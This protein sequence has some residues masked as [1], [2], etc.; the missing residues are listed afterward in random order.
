MLPHE[1]ML[2]GKLGGQPSIA[3][4]SALNAWYLSDG[5]PEL[6]GLLDSGCYSIDVPEEGALL[7]ITWLV[8]R[9]HQKEAGLVLAAIAPYFSRLRFYP[10]PG[11]PFRVDSGVFLASAGQSL[12]SIRMIEPDPRILAQEES[13]RI[14]RPLYRKMVRLFSETV[15][16]DSPSIDRHADGSWVCA[17]TRRFNVVGGWPCRNYPSDW[18][19]RASILLDEIRSA[20]KE[21]KCC[22]SQLKP[23]GSFGTLHD[24]LKRCSADAAALS[25]RDVGRI[26]LV[27][28]RHH[29]R[30]EESRNVVVNQQAQVRK[31]MHSA[32]A[33]VVAR[34]LEVYQSE[35]GITEIAPIIG[36]VTETEEADSGVPAGTPV[37][38]LI[39]RKALRCLCGSPDV[40]VE[41]GVVKSGESLAKII[42]RLTAGVWAAGFEDPKL[43]NLVDAIYRAFRRRRSLLLLNLEKQVDIEELPW[44]AAVRGFRNESLSTAGIARR[45]LKDLAALTVRAFPQSIIPNKLLREFKALAKTAGLDLPLVEEIAA[46]IFMGDFSQ[47]FTDAAKQTAAFMKDS[48]YERYYRI[49]AESI[50]LLPDIQREMSGGFRGRGSA[51]VNPLVSLCSERA[52]IQAG[53]TGRV[54]G[55]GMILE[56]AQ[57]LTTHNLAVLFREFDLGKELEADLPAMAD[58]CLLWILARRRAD[59]KSYHS[60]LIRSKNTA[61]AWRQLVFYLS[62]VSPRE[63]LNYLQRQNSRIRVIMPKKHEEFIPVVNGLALVLNRHPEQKDV[64]PFLGWTK[65]EPPV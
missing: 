17:S 43:R 1:A 56:Q 27:L 62:F 25:G 36:P 8:T 3:D 48:L 55:N 51:G 4:R 18:R 54:V 37:P 61:Y 47:K 42:P 57:I 19:D 26:R 9:G 40:L 31:P 32:V 63:A 52:G 34:R 65:Q 29:V 30:A 5:F 10:G 39:E 6:V 14:W 38:P 21:H 49:D 2:A 59:L 15:E 16:G 58:R 46:D 12:E 24:C 41:R 13:I 28:A 22:S 20:L 7:V 50:R 53:Q 60:R 64:Y 35:R 33:D 45:T 23:G 44:I 11:V